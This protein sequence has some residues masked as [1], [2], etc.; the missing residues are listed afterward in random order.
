MGWLNGEINAFPAFSCP[1]AIFPCRT[2]CESLASAPELPV[3]LIA[4]NFKHFGAMF[5]LQGNRR[6]Q[7]GQWP[8]ALLLLRRSHAYETATDTIIMVVLTW[9]CS[10]CMMSEEDKLWSGAARRP[11]SIGQQIVVTH[12]NSDNLYVRALLETVTASQVRLVT[13]DEIFV[14][15]STEP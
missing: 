15:K 2:H 12:L 7:A 5:C 10:L 9:R 6:Y 11:N 1:V 14:S 8:D 13:V 4:T 3:P